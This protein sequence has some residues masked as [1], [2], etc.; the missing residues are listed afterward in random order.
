MMKPVA[1]LA[2][3]RRKVVRKVASVVVGLAL[4]SAAAMTAVAQSTTEPVTSSGNGTTA[5]G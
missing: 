3:L 1:N 4:A 2:H 5:N